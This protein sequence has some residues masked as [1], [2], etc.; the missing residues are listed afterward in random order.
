MS[1]SEG[2]LYPPGEIL[3]PIMGKTDYEYVILWM[4]SNNDI[5]EWS[6]FTA[7]ISESTLSG[8]L[9]KL[10][11][12]SYIE[13]PEKGKYQIT[14]EGIDR[15]GELTYDKKSGQ[16]KLRFPPE[17][18]LKRRNYDHWILWMLYNNYSCKWSDF[19]QEPLQ[20]NQSSLSNNL[21][22]L[23]DDGLVSRENKEY[24]ISP[25]GKTE[26]LRI[27]KSYDLDRQSILEQESKRIEEIT[28]KTSKFFQKYKIEDNELK[29]RYL[30]QVL[31]LS[32]SK[33]ESMLKIEDDFNKILLFLSINHPDQYPDFT[34]AIDFSSK[35]RID[36]TTLNYYI[37]EIVDNEF[38]D[39]KFFKIEGENGGTYYFQKNETI[40]KVLNA[41]VEKHITKFTYLNK[42]HDTTTMDVGLLL[43]KILDDVCGNLFNENLKPSLRAF[44]PRYIRYL[45]YKIETEKKLV[46]SEA[47][48]EGFVWQS[49]FEEFQ[50]FEPSNVATVGEEDEY[51]YALDCAIFNT[52]EIMSLSKLDFLNTDDVQELY[53]LNKIDL[54]NKIVSA[55]SK[56]K[57]PKAKE[58]FQSINK[59]LETINKLIL[60]DII[61]TAD[62]NLIDSIKTTNE[63]IAKYP[64][65]FIG[66]LFQSITY[67]LMDNYEKALEII[68]EALEAAPNVLLICQK[69]Q[70]LNRI[71]KGYKALN[72]IN[73]SLSQYPDNSLLLRIKYVVYI[74]NWMAMV[75]D[76]NDPLEVI[77]QLI[78]LNPHNE[79]ILLLKCLYYCEIK[80]YKEAKKLITKEIKFDNFNK[81]PRI[82]TIA[83]FIIACSYLAR[84]KFD[85]SL[86]I[87]NLALTLYPDHPIS[88]LTKS[89]V[90]GYNL[91][92]RF[93][94]KEPNIDKF[95]ELIKLTISLESIKYN[96]IMYLILKSHILNG[97]GKYDESINNIDNAIEL[98]PTLNVLYLRKT[99]LLIISKR[100]SEAL[101]LI[102]KLLES[103]PHLKE[104]LLK[105]KSYLHFIL[106]QYEEGLRTVDEAIEL[107]PQD[108]DFINNKATILAYLGRKEEAI[109]TAEYLI[110]LNPKYGN[111]Y[112]TYGEVLMVLEDYE[113]AIEKFKEALNLEPTG[114]FAYQTCLKLGDCFK[115]LG[116]LENSLEYYE[117][118][119]KLIEKMHP[120]YREPYQRELE[121]LISKTKALIEG[122]NDN[123]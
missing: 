5:C 50:T 61:A 63:I 105:Q 6:D 66:Y 109:N 116:N 25:L 60:K 95:T 36:K 115:K 79:E 14:S 67:F 32:Y 117:K 30:D 71:D 57:V 102:K 55:L 52:L 86:E 99:Y 62:N 18:I 65:D 1:R 20:I 87:A 91:I 24:V 40:E 15:F 43:D 48:L 21:N 121:E 85:K 47:K 31:K 78:T 22:I 73:D 80:K 96:K 81:N 112:D 118:G 23:I 7:E 103:H 93:S 106:K 33:V 110:N 69:A 13:K 9:K 120:S 97:L 51:S 98:I 84:G 114:W 42:F 76:Y 46:D 82:D 37:R 111:S 68:D 89:L 4:L 59:K 27:L 101:N 44:L 35:Y 11:N 104:S 107:N 10:M 54:Y 17:G 94:F 90:L 88:F 39:V 2:I 41:I 38:F 58:L 8:N 64:N 77:D 28:E 122:S 49:I 92:Y 83:Y 123:E 45:A 19:R 29:F 34:S 113:N 100:E 56:N 75:K 72:V 26:Y 53:N 3:N 119:K 12:K 74:S 70:I 16:R 108:P